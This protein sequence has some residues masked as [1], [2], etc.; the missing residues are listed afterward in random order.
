MGLIDMD[1]DFLR[2]NPRARK[3]KRFIEY[4]TGFSRY[5]SKRLVSLLELYDT[6]TVCDI[7]ANSGQFG[8]D[9]HSAGFK[10]KLISYEPAKKPFARRMDSS[11]GET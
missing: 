4:A 10:G 3:F 9:L 11:A 5:S 2:T 8:V 7:G 6:P 1:F